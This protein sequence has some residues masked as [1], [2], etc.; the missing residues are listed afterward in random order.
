MKHS[1]ILILSLVL[2]VGV[3]L[4]VWGKMDIVRVG[5]RLEEL[6]KKKVVLERDQE[7]L[8]LRISQLMAP[9][10]IAREAKDKLG[11][12]V[13]GPGQI[14]LVRTKPFGSTPDPKESGVI[15]VAQKLNAQ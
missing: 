5:Y 10:R 4:Y 7:V 15:R 12:R 6:S 14:I 1:L 3:L 8:R 9:D 11:M 13:P 2:G